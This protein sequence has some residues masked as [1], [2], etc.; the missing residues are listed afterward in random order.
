[1]SINWNVW[2]VPFPPPFP[3]QPVCRFYLPPGS[4]D[5]HFLSAS[6]SE[7][8]EVHARYPHFVLESSAAFYTVLPDL[9]T[10]ACP[11]G[12]GFFLAPMFRV[13]NGRADTNHRYTLDSSQRDQMVAQGWVSEGYGPDGVA[14][15]A[16]QGI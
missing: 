15:C 3:M 1:V 5:S 10:G 4:G 9:A 12:E 13:W 2:D 6:A 16:P 14:F 11:K 8:A 7:C